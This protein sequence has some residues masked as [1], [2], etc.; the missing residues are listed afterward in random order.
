MYQEGR[1]KPILIVAIWI[2]FKFCFEGN[3]GGGCL[4]RKYQ[5]AMRLLSRLEFLV[6]RADNPYVWDYCQETHDLGEEEYLVKL[7]HSNFFKFSNP[8]FHT[9]PILKS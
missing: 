3:L 7:N 6:D 9:R 4:S 8:N 5:E 1:R 2:K